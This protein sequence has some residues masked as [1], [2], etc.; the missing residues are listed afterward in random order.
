MF[1]VRNVVLQN[2]QVTISILLACAGN[3]PPQLG[4][5]KDLMAENYGVAVSVG[6]S[7]GAGVSLGITIGVR[8]S[9]ALGVADGGIDV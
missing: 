3:D 4:Q 7:L 5:F 6:V 2:S 8:V 9:V 1:D